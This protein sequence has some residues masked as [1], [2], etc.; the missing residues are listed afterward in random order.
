MRNKPLY[1]EES[2]GHS[3]SLEESIPELRQENGRIQ[4]SRLVR[5][6]LKVAIRQE[7]TA[8]QRECVEMYFMQGMTMDRIG[9][10]L[11]IGKST[12]YK[13]IETA[14][15]HIRRVLA[16]AQAFQAAMDEEEED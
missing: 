16:Y 5:A 2:M 8:R 13:H 6:A 14:K 15:A 11:G 7:L 12:V 9:E 4:S 3:Q 10:K 1:L